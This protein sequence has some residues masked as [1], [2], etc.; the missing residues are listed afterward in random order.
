[1]PASCR[2]PPPEPWCGDNDAVGLC[3]FHVFDLASPPRGIG[4]CA[5]DCFSTIITRLVCSGVQVGGA[6]RRVWKN[7]YTFILR[8]PV[9]NMGALGVPPKGFVNFSDE[10]LESQAFSA[11]RFSSPGSLRL[12]PWILIIESF[13]R[14]QAGSGYSMSVYN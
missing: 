5:C 14:G 7:Y 6:T 10:L 4:A 11:G 1:M 13:L 9:H 8:W 2:Y 3:H 12:G